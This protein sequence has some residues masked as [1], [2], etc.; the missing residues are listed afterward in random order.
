MYTNKNNIKLGNKGEVRCT[1][2][3]CGESLVPEGTEQGTE[4]NHVLCLG[5]CE[6]LCLEGSEEHERR[7]WWKMGM[8]KLPNSPLHLYPRYF[9]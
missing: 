3:S 9:L 5:Q 6:E 2:A 1:L 4:M 7:M 8:K